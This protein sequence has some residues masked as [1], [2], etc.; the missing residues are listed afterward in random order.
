MGQDQPQATTSGLTS[1][2]RELRVSW[3][4]RVSSTWEQEAERA[5][6][7]ENLPGEGAA[8]TRSRWRSRQRRGCARGGRWRPSR[9]PGLGEPRPAR[10]APEP[11][12]APRVR[13]LGP[14]G[15]PTRPRPG[16]PS[17]PCSPSIHR[18]GESRCAPGA[19]L[20]SLP[21][22]SFPPAQLDVQ[23]SARSRPRPL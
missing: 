9:A 3:D 10:L 16:L 13:P 19:S 11:P 15:A 4:R 7:E 21:P 14:R 1:G 18:S 22:A 5:T 23:F 12:A 17:S 6:S 8:E 20:L 2:T